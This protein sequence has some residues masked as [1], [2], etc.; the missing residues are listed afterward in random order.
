MGE[1]PGAVGRRGAGVPAALELARVEIIPVADL[2]PG[3]FSAELQGRD[4]GRPGVSLI[5]VEAAP[6]L[7]PALTHS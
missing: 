6:G 1:A 5:L 2:D 7:T 4:H 3:R